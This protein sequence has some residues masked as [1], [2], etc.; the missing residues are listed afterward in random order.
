MHYQNYALGLQCVLQILTSCEL[1]YRVVT[2][3]IV[4]QFLLKNDIIITLVF[5]ISLTVP[6]V[7]VQ[8]VSDLSVEGTPASPSTWHSVHTH[9]WQ[10]CNYFQQP[11]ALHAYTSQ[12]GRLQTLGVTCTSALSHCYGGERLYYSWYWLKDYIVCTSC[13]F[14][15]WMKAGLRI[16]LS[17]QTMTLYCMKLW[18]DC[19]W[20]APSR[21]ISALATTV[22][23][24]VGVL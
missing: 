21:A 7:P 1:Y 4:H 15:H 12:W 13:N 23:C 22:P 24:K 18:Y 19:L 14:N 20:G 2:T 5:G 17:Y 9:A 3:I 6:L 16:K 8:T 11:H 10:R